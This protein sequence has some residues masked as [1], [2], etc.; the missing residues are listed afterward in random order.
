MLL[1]CSTCNKEREFDRVKQQ[2]INMHKYACSVCHTVH[3]IVK[4][5]KKKREFEI[6]KPKNNIEVI[7]MKKNVVF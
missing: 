7:I 1:L 2:V 5:K 4:K 3:F 6:S